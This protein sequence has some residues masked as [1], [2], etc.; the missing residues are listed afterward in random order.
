MSDIF[1]LETLV[2]PKNLQNTLLTYSKPSETS[3]MEYFEK[4]VKEGFQLL[5]FFTKRPS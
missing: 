3:K 1:F 2:C 5:T 4:K